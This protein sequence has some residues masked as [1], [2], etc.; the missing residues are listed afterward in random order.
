[1]RV[2]LCISLQT[3]ATKW[4]SHGPYEKDGPVKVRSYKRMSHM[5]KEYPTVVLR[6]PA[7]QPA[8]YTITEIAS[9]II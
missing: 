2:A 3:S 1:M 7:Q 5:A 4:S 8:R 6:L 9:R